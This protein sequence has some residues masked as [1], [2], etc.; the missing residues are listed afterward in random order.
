[1][2]VCTAPMYMCHVCLSCLL[3][4][5]EAIRSTVL[6]IYKTQ[7]RCW[8]SNQASLQELQVLLTSESISPDLL[9]I[10]LNKETK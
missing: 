8:D 7:Y 1:M 6:H 4:S 10:T 9:N 2:S 5:E 3:W